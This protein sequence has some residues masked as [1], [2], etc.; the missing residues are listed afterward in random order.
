MCP[1]LSHHVPADINWLVTGGTRE[2]VEE[3][4][5]RK[6][7][8]NNVHPLNTFTK[9]ADSVTTQEIKGRRCYNKISDLYMAG[10]ETNINIQRDFYVL[11]IPCLLIKHTDKHTHTRAR[12]HARTH[13][14]G[15]HSKS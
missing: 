5:G 13:T 12:T 8:I 1:W 9:T 7:Q 2:A 11:S 4:L 14:Y 3:V 6:T 15:K 10:P